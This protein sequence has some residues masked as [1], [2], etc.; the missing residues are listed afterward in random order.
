MKPQDIT[1]LNVGSQTLLRY[2]DLDY[3]EWYA[4]S[5]FIDNSLHSYLNNKEDLNKLGID[6]CDTKI[7]IVDDEDEGEV[8]NIFDNSGGV[9]PND[10]RRLL[11]MG[12]PKENS[13][14][15]LSEF[16]M[17]MKTAAIWLGKRVEIETKHYLNEEAFKIVIDITK[18]GSDDEVSITNVLPSSSIKGYT[19]IKISNLNRRITSKKKRIKDSLS[20]IYRKFIERGD[21]SISF[22]DEEITPF[23]YYLEQDSMGNDQKREF[24][25][26]L[27]NGKSC[28]GWLGIM[29]DKHESGWK[30][31]SVY[32]GF[33]TYRYDRLIQGYPENSWRPKEVFGQEGGSNTTKNQRLI[34]ELDMTDFKVAHTKNKINFLGDEEAE[35]RKQLGEYCADIAREADK[36]MKPK[37]VNEY[38]DNPDSQI[39]KQELEKLLPKTSVGTETISFTEDFIKKS[40]PDKIKT[41]YENNEPDYDFSNFKDIDGIEKSVLAYDFLDPKLPYMIMDEIDDNLIVC[42]NI[43]HPYMSYLLTEGTVEQQ[44]THRINCMFDA[45]S[46]QNCTNRYGDY[47]PED[48]RI[49]KDLFL[50]KWMQNIE[51]S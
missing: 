38:K 5:E 6:I 47:T 32:S 49:T 19:K 44:L 3:D 10:F 51:K 36:K 15:Q 21:L 12:I 7:S 50:K 46:I 24:T 40:S 37:T 2:A 34:G 43:D 42:I 27:D 14:Y 48:I 41:I 9:H 33:S 22:L 1:S 29:K 4:M 11:S 45:L 25:I 35:F 17:G 8:L 26:T 13:E 28:K 16:G 31:R 23:I 20:S 39:V 18:L 30:R